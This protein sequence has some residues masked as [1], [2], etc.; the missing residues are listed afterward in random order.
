MRRTLAITLLCAGTA[1]WGC[2]SKSQ[3]EEFEGLGYT[4]SSSEPPPGVFLPL[5]PN[6]LAALQERGQ[7]LYGMERTLRMG[8]E[9]GAYKVGVPEGDVIMPLVDVDP[10]GRSGQVIFLRWPRQVV[11]EGGA[12]NPNDAKQWLMVSVLL[13]PDKV[14][15]VELQDGAVSEQGSLW[16]RAHQIIAAAEVLREHSPGH[17]FHLFTLPEVMLTKNKRAPA[18]L[19]TH[20]YAMS[21]EG[22]GPDLEVILDAPRRK[23]PP[24]VLETRLIH[25]APAAGR[26]PIEVELRQPA[27]AT[28][29]RV[30]MRG[31]QSGDVAV[32][33][34]TTRWAISASDGRVVRS[35]DAG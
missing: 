15:D 23:R 25:A 12:L 16:R 24:E 10:G 9:H 8:Y 2:A 11:G 33:A 27:P 17:S 29:A 3:D 18:K 22:D 32:R 6:D 7:L 30:M 26:D 35:D 1:S 21:A 13:G 14:I 20:V 4:A 28:V 19:V 5:P 34:G 31:P